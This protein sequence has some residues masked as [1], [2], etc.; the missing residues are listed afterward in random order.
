MPATCSSPSDLANAI[1]C[2][3]CLSQTELMCVM[4]LALATSNGYTLPG[5]TNAVITDSK[6]VTCLTDKQM[7]QALAGLLAGSTLDG[8]TV[9]QMRARIKCL[10]CANPRQLKATLLS[11]FCQY[12]TTT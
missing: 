10:A 7:L 6:C 5:D 2:L 8:L 4:I 3:A 9:T 12:I 1:P 11:Q